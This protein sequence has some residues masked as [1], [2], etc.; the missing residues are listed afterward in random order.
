ME[1][2]EFNP[3]SAFLFI[4]AGVIVAFVIAQSVFFLS[5]AWRRARELGIEVSVL[6]RVAKSSAV[7]TIA[8]AV[9]IILG[10]ITLSKFLG[11]ALPWLRLSVLGALTYEL[12]AATSAA[13]A[14][15][16]SISQG[17]TDP[18][19]Y[20]TIAWVMTLGIMSGLIIITLFLKR[21]Q[22]GIEGLKKRDTKWG[23]IFITAIFMGMISAFLGMIFADITSG[24]QGW[25]P[26]F[27][28]LVSSLVM[29]ICGFFVRVLK[30]RWMEDYALPISM[31]AAMALSIPITRLLG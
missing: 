3:N 16:V 1:K 18:Q 8:P 4:T 7:F 6:K 9:A 13:S 10:V 29:L 14:L 30:V 22:G 12:P 17:I 26:V 25:I 11:L 27:V 31:L 5:K 15:G 24:I 28:M 20:S 23:E 2:V 19:A 21:V